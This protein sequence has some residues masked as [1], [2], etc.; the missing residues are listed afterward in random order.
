MNTVTKL[1]IIAV[2]CLTA[3]IFT[4]KQP[5]H[6]KCLT[7]ASATE[8]IKGM[9]IEDN[10][11]VKIW[12]N[13]HDGDTISSALYLAEEGINGIQVMYFNQKGCAI[14]ALTVPLTETLEKTLSKAHVVYERK[15]VLGQGT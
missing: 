14:Y 3:L 8:Q 1:W 7:A 4:Y 2:L 10:K 11:W 5:A 6:S 12:F 9:A 15:A 13:M